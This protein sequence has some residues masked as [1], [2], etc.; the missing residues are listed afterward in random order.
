MIISEKHEDI[1]FYSFLVFITFLLA[2]GVWITM[3]IG[4]STMAVVVGGVFFMMCA[5]LGLMSEEL[6]G[7]RFG[8]NSNSKNRNKWDPSKY[9]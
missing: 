2:I 6:L 3:T 9:V 4:N 8:S 7:P 1:L 5:V